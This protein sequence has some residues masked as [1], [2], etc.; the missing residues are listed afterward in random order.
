[1]KWAIAIALVIVAIVAVVLWRRSKS[2][3]STVEPF[4][5]G[6]VN[7]S[8]SGQAA[9]D[10]ALEIRTVTDRSAGLR[11]LNGGLK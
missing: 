9:I 3:A 1:M 4:R 11:L 8:A 2:G 10:N 6:R 5:P 7:I